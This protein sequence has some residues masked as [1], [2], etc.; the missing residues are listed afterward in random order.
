MPTPAYT[1]EYLPLRDALMDV[2]RTVPQIKYVQA[3]PPY[4]VPS[5]PMAWV[6]LDSYTRSQ[7]SQI[8]PIHWRFLVRVASPLSG[9]QQAEDDLV[10]AA[11]EIAEAVD[12][13]P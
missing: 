9:S 13:D 5:N 2:V 8:V 3:Y 12:R 11:L 6:L 10:A 7:A 1:H 4:S